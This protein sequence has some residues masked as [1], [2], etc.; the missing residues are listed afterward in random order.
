M[1]TTMDSTGLLV[2][3]CQ[4]PSFI[5]VGRV[6]TLEGINAKGS[7]EIPFIARHGEGAGWAKKLAN[8][9]KD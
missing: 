3:K 7:D 9:R 1:C 2:M 4:I 8:L 6:P 5:A